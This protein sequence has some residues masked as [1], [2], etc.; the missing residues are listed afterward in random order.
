MTREMMT[1]TDKIKNPACS[2]GLQSS[3]YRTEMIPMHP[4]DFEAHLAWITAKR[5]ALKD[6]FS[7]KS[8][9][10]RIVG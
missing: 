1:V 10:Y 7:E 6:A 4:D 3:G 5:S 8:V 9:Y 2:P